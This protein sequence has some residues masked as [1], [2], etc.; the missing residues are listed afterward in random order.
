MYTVPI[1]QNPS[2]AVSYSFTEMPNFHS[3]SY[4]L[5][6]WVGSASGKF[7]MSVSNSVSEIKTVVRSSSK[8]NLVDVIIVEDDPYFFLQFEEYKARFERST[9]SVKHDEDRFLTSLAP[10]YLQ[11]DYQGRVIRLDTF[12]KVTAGSILIIDQSG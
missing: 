2:G 8:L 9:A 5:R 11:F 3:H 10:S 6:P 1:G 4:V 7:T 12:S